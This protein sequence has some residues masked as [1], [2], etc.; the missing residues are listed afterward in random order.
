MFL[1]RMAKVA[2]FF[3]LLATVQSQAQQDP[4]YNLYFF[5]Q[6]MINPAYIGL[7]KDATLNLISRK[8]WVGIDGAPLT[9]FLSFSTSVGDRFGIGGTITS[10]QL[11]INQNLEGQLAFSF[12]VIEKPGVTL[13]LGA[14]GGLI[15]YRYDYSKLNLE[16]LDDED[17]DMSL[18]Q[19]TRP[20]FGAGIFLK[21]DRF[22]A[23]LSS[24]RILNVDIND[25]VMSST[26]YQRHF[27]FSGGALFNNSFKSSVRIKPSF[28]LRMVPEGNMALDVSLHALFIE[29][30][31][32]G[33]TVRNLS[34]VGINTQLQVSQRT[35]LGYGFELPTN[36]LLTR[37]YG[38]HELSLL[39]EFSPL[40]SQH[41]IFR[42]F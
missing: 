39:I 6:G 19:Y 36:A 10:D 11:G 21:T 33:I 32:A 35:R 34:A 24:P 9:N 22:Y 15:N 8:Q 40:G 28:L 12:N 41:K 13:A 16:Y 38:T 5:N 31:W 37:N 7:Y 14:Q 30:L 3:L 17:L 18:T 26:R 27:Y 4:L 42:Y 25:G 29:T 2:L 1:A 23:G 20:N